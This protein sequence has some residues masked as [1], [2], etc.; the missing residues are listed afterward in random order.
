MNNESIILKVGGQK[1]KGW[2]AATIEKSL[3][4][5]TGTFGL[6]ATDI[7]PGSMEKWGIAMGDA[8]SIEIYGQTIISGYIEDISIDYDAESH[9]IQ[10][11]GRDKTCDLVDCSVETPNEWKNQSIKSIVEALCNPFSI[12]VEIDSSVSTSVI[13]KIADKKANEGDTVFDIISSLCKVHAILPVSY[14]DGK[15]T[16]TRAGT[17]HVNDT[18]E[19]GRNVKSG[20]L[21]QS[22]KDRFKTYTVKGQAIGKDN[23]LSVTSIANLSGQATDD[24][25]LRYRPMVIF[26]E[27]A[28]NGNGDCIKRAEWEARIRA[29]KSRS[30]NYQ[31]QGWV[32]DNHDIWPLNS[33]VRV[34]DFFLNIDST[35]LISELSFSVDSDSGTITN[36][37]LVDPGMFDPMPFTQ[38]TQIKTESDWRT[39]LAIQ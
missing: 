26:P 9:N 31:V 39:K 6:A 11:S 25:I 2:T 23:I 28:V 24:V 21:E 1:F 29:G 13:T 27:T 3:Y 15:L 17:N 36:L 30:V 4:N 14:G 5:M 20:S 7:F 8:C 18:L 33:L 22:N 16:L 37:S 38:N 12:D 32:Q 34:K 35:L 10:I 19:L